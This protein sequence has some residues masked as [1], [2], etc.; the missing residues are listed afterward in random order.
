MSDARLYALR[1][2]DGLGG[3]TIRHVAFDPVEVSAALALDAVERRKG[4]QTVIFAI[5][6]TGEPYFVTA[7][8]GRGADLDASPAPFTVE[9]YD[10]A[11]AYFATLDADVEAA[12]A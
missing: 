3:S 10:A 9:E 5:A 2:P 12:D 1:C 6:A 4:S 11:L 7:P 8:S